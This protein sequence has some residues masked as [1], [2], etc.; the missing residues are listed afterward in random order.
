MF[1]FKK[2][3]DI[4]WQQEICSMKVRKEKKSL[5]E[6]NKKEKKNESKEKTNRSKKK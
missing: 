4:K 2:R 1:S 3:N 6:E 5:D